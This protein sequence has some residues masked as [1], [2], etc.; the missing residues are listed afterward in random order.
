[1]VLL[2]VL[3][4][5]AGLIVAAELAVM[6]ARTSSLCRWNRWRDGGHA[7]HGMNVDTSCM[8]ARSS[9]RAIFGALLGLSLLVEVYLA[10]GYPDCSWTRRSR[11][12]SLRFFFS[13]VFCRSRQGC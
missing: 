13:C 2:A 1:M 11:D 10:Q 5:H 4:K 7:A 12:P 3:W 6:A 9:S 8:K